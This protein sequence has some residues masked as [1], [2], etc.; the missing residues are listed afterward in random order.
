MNTSERPKRKTLPLM[1]GSVA[2]SVWMTRTS[3][4]ARDTSWPACIS[5]WRAKS[6]LFRWS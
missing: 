1:A 5:S 2:R 4:F 3:E 6:S